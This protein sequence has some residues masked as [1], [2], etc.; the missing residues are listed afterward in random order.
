MF[1]RKNKVHTALILG[2]YIAGYNEK[3]DSL[4]P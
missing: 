3:K 1:I 4:D 2:G